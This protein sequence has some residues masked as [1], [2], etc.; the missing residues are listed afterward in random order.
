MPFDD[1]AFKIPLQLRIS[2]MARVAVTTTPRHNS[3]STS[4]VSVEILRFG[5]CLTMFN[6]IE[7]HI[8]PKHVDGSFST[9]T[10]QWRSHGYLTPRW[11]KEHLAYCDLRSSGWGLL[12]RLL[13]VFGDE[14]F[15][16]ILPLLFLFFFG[17][18]CWGDVWVCNDLD[19]FQPSPTCGW[20][21]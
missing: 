1:H 6:I 13:F 12:N 2:K 17:G 8:F 3:V 5:G 9:T 11:G 15:W 21:W 20:F 19:L 14:A 16:C 4:G 10:C 7:S 18:F